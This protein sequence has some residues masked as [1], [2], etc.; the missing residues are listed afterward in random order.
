MIT[1]FGD[2]RQISAKDLAF[3]SKNNV[4]IKFLQKVAEA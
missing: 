4:T 1:I 2:F 3:F